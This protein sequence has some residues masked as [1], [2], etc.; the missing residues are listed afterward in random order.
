LLLVALVPVAAAKDVPA[1]PIPQNPNDL[2]KVRHFIGRRITPHRIRSFRAPQN[3]YMAPDPDNNI[4]DDAYMTDSYLR[5]G[6]RGPRMRVRST[7]QN[8]DCASVTFDRSGRIVTICV[9]VQGP[10][11]MLFDAHT[12]ETKAT[13]ELPPRSGAGTGSGVFNDFSGGGYFYLNNHYDAV[14][15]TTNRQIWIVGEARTSTGRTFK[16]ERIIDLTAEVPAGEALIS[17]LPDWEGRL[18][19]IGTKGTVGV[20]H[21]HSGRVQAAVLHGEANA[22]SFAVDRRGGVYIVSDHA[23]YRFGLGRKGAPKIVWR[24]SYDRGRRVKPGQASR[25]SGTTPTVIGGRYVAITD[26]ADPRMHV[27]VYKRKKHVKGRRLLCKKG[28]FRRGRSDT[29]Q[30]LVAVRHS[31]IV[32][33][34]YG[35][36]GPTATR[37]GESTSRGLARVHFS[38]RGCRVVWSNRLRAPSVV[39]KVSLRNGVLYTYTKPRRRQDQ[40]DAWYFTAIGFRTGRT[41]YRRLAGTGLGFNNNYAPVTIGPVGKTA[42]VGTLGGLVELSDAKP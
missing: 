30:S 40:V 29:D 2:A 3:P 34:N 9:G 6:P 10:R 24:Q 18:W 15:P 27:L 17:V 13:L 20:V 39:P 8:A 38:S 4:H 19:F 14:V 41:V 5:S 42:Y 22:N 32:E 7:D 21:R 25:G 12:L 33:N 36:S 37:D 26:N 11:L 23:L 31:L 35:Y 1:Q 16:V 28:V